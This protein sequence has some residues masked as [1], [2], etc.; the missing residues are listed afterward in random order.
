MKSEFKTITTVA[1]T[2]PEAA[3][4][5]STTTTTISTSSVTTGA[6]KT[7]KVYYI[8]QKCE[9]PFFSTMIRELL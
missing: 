7:S 5:S 8:C 1:A 6:G 9:Y 2:A 4:T 3:T